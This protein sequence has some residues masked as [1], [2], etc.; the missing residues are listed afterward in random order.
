MKITPSLFSGL[1]LVFD[2]Q[3]IEYPNDSSVYISCVVDLHKNGII[4][5]S[6][7]L[8][9]N[10]L[11]S[12]PKKKNASILGNFNFDLSSYYPLA[13]LTIQFSS[14]RMKYCRLVHLML[15]VL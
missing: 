14:D 6:L 5:S 3:N 9:L 8:R 13:E 7:P 1:N 10:V 11:P 12:R 4:T 15:M 2:C